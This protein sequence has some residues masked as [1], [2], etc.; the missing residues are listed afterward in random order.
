MTPRTVLIGSTVF[1]FV[2]MVMLVAGVS[3]PGSSFTSKLAGS[4]A[5]GIPRSS[6]G[7]RSS[8]WYGLVLFYSGT[9]VL[10]TA[11]YLLIIACSRRP[12]T[13]VR[14]LYWVAALWVAPLLIAPPLLS[15][16][17]YTYGAEGQLVS[18]GGNPYRQGLL[19]LR[20]TRF[21]DLS[22]PR[23]HSTH[24]PYG[25]IFFDLARLN[26]ALWGN[27]VLANVEGYRLMA[28]LGV[29]LI[30]L[31]APPLA[32]SLG[33]DPSTALVLAVLNPV[34]LL[35]LIGG[36]HNDAL[37][38]G[39][40]VAGITL[41]LAGRSLIGIV[42]C[43]LGAAIKV[44]AALGFVY[45]GWIWA[46]A[47][48]SVRRKLEF[49]A[50]S[51]GVGAACLAVITALSGLGWGWIVNL[52]DPGEVT[53]WLDPASAVGLSAFHLSHLFGAT[54]GAPTFVSDPRAGSLLIAAAAVVALLVNTDHIGIARSMGWS[55]LAVVL[56]GPIVWPWYETWGLVFLAFAADRWSRRVVI[57]VVTLGTFATFPSGLSLTTGEVI[58]TTAILLVVVGVALTALTQ[59]RRRLA[60]Q[61][62]PQSAAGRLTGS[63]SVP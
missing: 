35:Y 17:V 33:Q 54:V 44:P 56:L 46:G 62:G 6:L 61:P 37:M 55:L 38:L 25:P 5:F 10:L 59:I 43:A 28:V 63:M 39:L 19:S 36:A 16:D 1:G 22:D 48:P 52:S 3:V 18:R 60:G 13:P 7:A 21:F 40:L 57:V 31:S 24:A 15:R 50:G 42:L 29:A 8:E 23:W 53:S 27:R 4:W 9:I 20:G 47:D 14:P 26:T 34:V 45:V 41:A 32:R 30:A 58:L 12:G 11:W 2:G 49:V 51:L